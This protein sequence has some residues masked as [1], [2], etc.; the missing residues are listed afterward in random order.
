MST[1]HIIYFFNYFSRLLQIQLNEN[2]NSFLLHSYFI[3][4]QLLLF[5]K[6]QVTKMF[7][8]SFSYNESQT[9]QKRDTE[10]T[11][12]AHHEC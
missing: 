12:H 1:A 5:A 11:A 10:R 8:F 6:F 4:F 2:E 3:W 7:F 9:Q